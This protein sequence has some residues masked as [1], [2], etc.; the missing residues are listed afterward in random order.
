LP[1]GLEYFM[2]TLPKV[3]NPA[4][5]TAMVDVAGRQFARFVLPLDPAVMDPGPTLEYSFN[6]ATWLPAADSPDGAVNETRSP[7][8]WVLDVAT[9]THPRAFFRAGISGLP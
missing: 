3:P 7:A 4:P 2:G 6:L 1:T 8:S 5:A 9:D